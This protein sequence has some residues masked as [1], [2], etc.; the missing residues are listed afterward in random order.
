MGR[1]GL[2]PQIVMANPWL[3]SL[4]PRRR[5][6]SAGGKYFPRRELTLVSMCQLIVLALSLARG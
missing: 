2:G 4:F 6:R 3:E 5:E 1:N